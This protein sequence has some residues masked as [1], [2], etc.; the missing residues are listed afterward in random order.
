MRGGDVWEWRYRVDTEGNSKDD[1]WIVIPVWHVFDH[2]NI[3]RM[4]DA[5][6]TETGQP[7]LVME[8]VDGVHLYVTGA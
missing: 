7:F 3:T 4:L 2:P 8:F 1:D 6:L 5:G